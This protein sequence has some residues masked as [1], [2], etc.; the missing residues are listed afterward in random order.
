MYIVIVCK[1]KAIVQLMTADNA[2]IAEQIN[3]TL[4]AAKQLAREIN[5]DI[6]AAWDELLASE[7]KY[8]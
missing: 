7:R 1:G 2:E 6:L 4:V 3:L 8:D 5:C